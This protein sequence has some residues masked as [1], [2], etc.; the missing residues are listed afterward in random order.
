[1]VMQTEALHAV[2]AKLAKIF[3]GRLS[4]FI[5]LLT[6]VFGLICTTQGVTCLSPLRRL[7]ECLPCSWGL[8]SLPVRLPDLVRPEFQRIS[9]TSA[10]K[11]LSAAFII[12]MATA[13]GSILTAGTIM[14]TVVHA[15]AGGVDADYDAAFRSAGYDQ[16]F[17]S[18]SWWELCF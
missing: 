4:M 10:K 9:W 2:V 12:G 13:I 8:P 14:D 15:L 18:G 5:P 3:S 11:M 1:M 16:G 7:W 6:L 17:S